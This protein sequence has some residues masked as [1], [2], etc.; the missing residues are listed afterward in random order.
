MEKLVGNSQHG[1]TKGK[2][3]ANL[4][5][6]RDEMPGSEDKGRAVDIIY[7]HFSKA[8]NT[9]S[10]KMLASKLG[11]YGTQPPE[12]EDRDGEQNEAPVIQWEMVSDLLHHLDIDKSMGPDGIH[13]R[14][15][16]ELVEVFTKPLS[17]L[18]QQSWLTGEVP[19]DWRL[20][21][22]MPM[23][24]KGQKE[25]LGSTTGLSA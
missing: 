15:L 17:I 3:L 9:V 18:Y 6:L 12:L 20:A 8:F 5:A 25:H 22:V 10:H 21:H 13:T 4:T 1:L 24:K 2:C 23:Y 11:H 14:V 16:R 7:L 19:V